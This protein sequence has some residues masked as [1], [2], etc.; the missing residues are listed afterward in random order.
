M[1]PEEY[2]AL[3]ALNKKASDLASK[4]DYLNQALTQVD[5]VRVVRITSRF[6]TFELMPFDENFHDSVVET[7]IRIQ[8]ANTE[9]RFRELEAEYT[10]R[11]EATDQDDDDAG[12]PY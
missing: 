11:T 6:R 7:A 8:L 2:S 9:R 12:I 1:T 5:M 3:K 4:I 10:L